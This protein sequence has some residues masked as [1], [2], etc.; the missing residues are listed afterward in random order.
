MAAQRPEAALTRL[1]A[2]RGQAR[3]TDRGLLLPAGGPGLAAGGARAR[4]RGLQQSLEDAE[5]AGDRRAALPR[6]RGDR[7]AGRGGGGGGRGLRAAWSGRFPGGGGRPG[8]EE[9][10]PGPGPQPVREG[11]GERGPV[12]DGEPLLVPARPAARPREPGHRRRARFPAGGDDRSPI[13]RGAQRVADP[14]GAR[15]GPGHGPAGAREL[16]TGGGAERGGLAPAGRRLQPDRRH[17]QSRAVQVA[18]ARWRGR[19]SG[20]PAAVR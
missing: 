20:P 9:R 13:G 17:H 15:A 11:E 10:K 18:D 16:G 19:A 8:P 14:G 6:A 2:L 5:A 4:R 3:E 1:V 7:P 12:R